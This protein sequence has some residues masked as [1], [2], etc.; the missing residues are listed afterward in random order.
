[1]G[2]MG[3]LSI[4]Q[5]IKDSKTFPCAKF[6]FSTIPF[7]KVIMNKL[8]F[9]FRIKPLTQALN[10]IRAQQIFMLQKVEAMSTFCNLNIFH[11]NVVTRTANNLNLH[12]TLLRDKLKQNVAHITW[13]LRSRP[14]SEG[15]Q[16]K[17]RLYNGVY[18]NRS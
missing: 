8:F 15:L 4:L 6:R 9:F 12:A 11:E 13:S 14:Q 2:L 3:K 7:V 5:N 17:A 16:C 18:A 10:Y 1:M